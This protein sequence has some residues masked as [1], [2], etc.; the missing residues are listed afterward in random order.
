MAMC[1]I[2]LMLRTEENCINVP[3]SPGK[4]LAPGRP[5][6]PAFPFGPGNPSLP[7]M[8]QLSV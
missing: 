6:K 3:L 4:P 1:S 2:I 7:K 8:M 5:G